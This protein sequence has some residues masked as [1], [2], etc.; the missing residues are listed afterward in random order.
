[1]RL[2]TDIRCCLANL[3]SQS[4]QAG[5]H[6]KPML[7]IVGGAT[8]FFFFG[9]AITAIPAVVAT[10]KPLNPSKIVTEIDPCQHCK[11]SGNAPDINP[12]NNNRFVAG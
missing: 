2:A 8:S 11:Y 7:F 1:M 10:D 12:V 4:S 9:R 5:K 3:F 6:L